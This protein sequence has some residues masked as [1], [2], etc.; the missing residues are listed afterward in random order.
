MQQ[1]SHTAKRLFLVTEEKTKLVC[2]RPS[3]AWLIR[4][5]LTLNIYRRGQTSGNNGGGSEKPAKQ[6]VK[7]KRRLFLVPIYLALRQMNDFHP[8]FSYRL[9]V[10]VSCDN[11]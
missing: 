8:F 10:H 2:V 11:R 6:E 5:I 9:K 4:W 3:K 1:P 7:L